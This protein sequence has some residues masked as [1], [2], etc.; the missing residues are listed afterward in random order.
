MARRVNSSLISRTGPG[1][2][3]ALGR[4]SALR[5]THDELRDFI[6]DEHGCGQ[7]GRREKDERCGH[8]IGH[9]STRLMVRPILGETGRWS[10][11]HVEEAV[12]ADGRVSM[13]Q[14]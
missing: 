13:R 3:D 2:G 12:G 4:R 8:L 11:E 10:L 5:P 7:A 6:S 14:R 1:Q 9:A